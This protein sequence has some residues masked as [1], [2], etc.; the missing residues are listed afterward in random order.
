MGDCEVQEGGKLEGLGLGDSQCF[1]ESAL[2]KTVSVT[3]LR[4]T[5]LPVV[6]CCSVLIQALSAETEQQVS[7]L[8]PSA[9]TELPQIFISS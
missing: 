4:R 7:C 2:G 6:S 5:S 8:L 3:G 9:F 1:V